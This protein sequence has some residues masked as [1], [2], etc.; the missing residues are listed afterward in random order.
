MLTKDEKEEMWLLRQSNNK[1]LLH[2]Q[3]YHPFVYTVATISSMHNHSPNQT[4]CINQNLTLSAIYFLIPIKTTYHFSQINSSFPLL[5]QEFCYNLPFGISERFKLLSHKLLNSTLTS[6]A[7]IPIF[8]IVS[9]FQTRS[10]ILQ[11]LPNKI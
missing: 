8:D 1:S 9:N 2:F 10:N 6:Y 5:G 11:T 3:N 7:L 4:K